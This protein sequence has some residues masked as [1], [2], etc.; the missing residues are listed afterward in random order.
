MGKSSDLKFQLRKISTSPCS[1]APIRNGMHWLARPR[2]PNQRTNPKTKQVL[3]L[4]TWKPILRIMF[5]PVTCW[6]SKKILKILKRK[7]R[8]TKEVAAGKEKCSWP[9]GVSDPI[10]QSWWA[11]PLLNLLY[12]DFAKWQPQ[13][14]PENQEGNPNLN[15]WF[16]VLHLLDWCMGKFRGN[17]QISWIKPW[18]PVD[19]PSNQWVINVT[20]CLDH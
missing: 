1:D 11:E 7:Y 17:A 4:W 20:C 13:S 12:P 19:F 6:K 15:P 10:F 2:M 5:A 16:F 9:H 18:F 8:K 14:L 3:A